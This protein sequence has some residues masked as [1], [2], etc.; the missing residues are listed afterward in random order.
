M[1]KKL[2]SNYCRMKLLKYCTALSGLLKENVLLLIS[3]SI[4]AYIM[5]QYDSGNHSII[6]L[7]GFIVESSTF[8]LHKP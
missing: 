4:F 8:Y 5:D 7:N 2:P 3:T 1:D 6:F